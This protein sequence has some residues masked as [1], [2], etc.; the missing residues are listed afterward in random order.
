MYL[1]I[2]LAIQRKLDEGQKELD[3]AVTSNS[4]EISLAHRYLAGI[5]IERHDSRKAAEEL[6]SYL[7]LVPKAPDAAVLQRKIKELRSNKESQSPFSNV[8]ER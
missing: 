5:H 2:T 8:Q 6:E 4:P 7:K 3:I 1:G